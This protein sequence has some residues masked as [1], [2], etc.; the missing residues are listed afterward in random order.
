[1]AGLFGIACVFMWRPF[2]PDG[3]EK[4][5][6]VDRNCKYYIG[7]IFSLDSQ[8]LSLYIFNKNFTLNPDFSDFLSLVLANISEFFSLFVLGYNGLFLLA[9]L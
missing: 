2:F 6:T 9:F 8:F 1:M 3:K 7:L 4:I 5:G